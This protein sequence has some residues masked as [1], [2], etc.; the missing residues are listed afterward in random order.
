MGDGA[1]ASLNFERLGLSSDNFFL[2]GKVGIGTNFQLVMFE[3]NP[4][5][6]LFLIPHHLTVN[7]GAK[8]SFLELGLGGTKVFGT[9]A[10]P[11][12]STS[13]YFL[14]PILGYRLQ[15]MKKGRTNFRIFGCLPFKAFKDY[16]QLGD[17]TFSPVGI[18]IGYCF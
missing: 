14:Y 6:S 12:F 13:K 18:S 16:R 8:K 15:P 10:H 1:L 17:Y 7:V 2:S 9:R 3:S 11:D 4:S 5:A